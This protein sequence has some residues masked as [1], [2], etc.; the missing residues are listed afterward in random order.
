MLQPLNYLLIK[1]GTQKESNNYFF[2]IKFTH[3]Q[4]QTSAYAC[5]RIRYQAFLLFPLWYHTEKR[6]TGIKYCIHPNK[7][8]QFFQIYHLK[9]AGSP[10]NT[11]KM[12]HVLCRYSP[13]NWRLWIWVIL[14]A[15]LSC[16]QANTVKCF[17]HWAAYG[18]LTTIN[19]IYKRFYI[20]QKFASP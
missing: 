2:I 13:T 17:M 8:W 15:R 18:I 16:I 9:N 14:Y 7:R 4:A 11:Y 5:G 19:Q 1:D 12:T 3:A 10:L 20:T 6:L